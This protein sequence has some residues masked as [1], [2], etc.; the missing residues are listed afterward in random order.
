M[1]FFSL[2]TSPS[3][4]TLPMLLSAC[5]RSSG[6]GMG[7][8]SGMAKGSPAVTVATTLSIL[9]TASAYARPTSASDGEE[10][11]GGSRAWEM[12]RAVWK[13]WSKATMVS[14]IMKTDSGT[15][16]GSVISRRVRGSKWKTQS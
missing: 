3:Y 15:P 16:T 7:S 14:Q 13:R 5:L 1:F 4:P 9:P 6:G 8:C 11:E 12:T 10:E 2:V